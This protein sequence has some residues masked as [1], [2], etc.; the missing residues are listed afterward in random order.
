MKN[1]IIELTPYLQAVP[2]QATPAPAKRSGKDALPYLS[3][4]VENIV[5]VGI[6]FCFVMGVVLS[7]VIAL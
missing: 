1:N 5:T 4:L 7:L 6:G 2:A 3:A